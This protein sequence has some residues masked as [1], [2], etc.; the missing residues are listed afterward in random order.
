MTASR[1]ASPTCYIDL[2]RFFVPK[3]FR[4]RSKWV[5][6]L[7]WIAQDW[8]FRPSPQFMY[9]WRRFLWRLFG[10]EVGRDVLI[11]PTARVTF[12]WNVTVGDN[13]WIGDYAELYSLAPI[14]IGRNSIVSQR[15]Y[16][17][18]GTH[19]YSKVDF[20]LVAKPIRIEDEVWIAAGAFIFPG[21]TIGKGSIVAAASLVLQD[22]P[23]A[24]ICAGH[25]ARP[26]RQRPIPE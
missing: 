2:S 3:E 6:Q 23:G 24:T 22:M 19:D 1:S 25:P 17:C 20:P 7:W 18:A 11:R 8:L 5:V 14:Q 21:V 4:G 26:I 9:G 15:A 13:S 10:A 16:L 12:P